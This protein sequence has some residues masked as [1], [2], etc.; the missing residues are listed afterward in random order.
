[1]NKIAK[2]LKIL[3]TQNINETVA[4]TRARRTKVSFMKTADNVFLSQMYRK[5]F[6]YDH[7]TF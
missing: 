2:T 7:P 1:M 6:I 3:V 5:R 4:V